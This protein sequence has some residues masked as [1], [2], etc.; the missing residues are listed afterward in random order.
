MNS[1]VIDTSQQKVG[2]VW[3]TRGTSRYNLYSLLLVAFFSIGLTS[4]IN[5]FQ[6]YILIADFSGGLANRVSGDNNVFPA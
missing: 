5:T 3:L 6:G 4:F 2:P 1:A